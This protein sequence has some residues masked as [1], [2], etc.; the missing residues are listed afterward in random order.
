VKN[1]TIGQKLKILLFNPD[2][3]FSE[4]LKNEVD[5]KH[6]ALIVLITSIISILTTILTFN[7]RSLLSIVGSAIVG[8]YLS[9][10]FITSLFYL[11]SLVFNP[12]GSFKRTLEFVSYGY[13]PAILGNVIYLIVCL[14]LR[15]SF[16]ISTQDP[17]LHLKNYR[18]LLIHNTLFQ[19]AMIL[20]FLFTLW[21]LYID[22][23]AVMYAR[24][25]SKKNAFLTVFIP[26]F[27]QLVLLIFFFFLIISF[28]K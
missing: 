19:A 7:D 23:Y 28:F 8:R 4:K 10:I 6:P 20:G 9:W 11:I 14:I 5:L 26:F 25:L 22:V 18:E 13:I 21:T 12:D 15:N 24:S 16:F 27:F 1:I 2:L 17:I 3:F